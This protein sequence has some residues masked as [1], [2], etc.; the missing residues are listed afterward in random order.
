MA[1]C[2]F[3]QDRGVIFDEQGNAKKCPCKVTKE[4]KHYIGELVKY[5]LDKNIPYKDFGKVEILKSGDLFGYKSFLKSYL[6]HR[7]FDVQPAMIDYIDITGIELM[8]AYLNGSD[9]DSYYRI[10]VLFL[11]LSRHYNN[12]AMGGVIH[13][14]LTYREEKGNTTLLYLGDL[15]MPR[16]LE[17]YGD[18]LYQ[19]I[20]RRDRK[21]IS[22][23][24]ERVKNVSKTNS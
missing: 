20:L 8:E 17:I 18:E 2:D 10:P 7:Y 5:T 12:K 23:F 16:V 14:T 22:K 3:C 24:S 6:F 1:E 9:F 15:E 11:D 4:L 13:Y 19:Y 21:N